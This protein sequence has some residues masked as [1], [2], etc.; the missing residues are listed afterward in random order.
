[1]SFQEL[2][3]SYDTE[4]NNFDSS[5]HYPVTECII[6]EVNDENCSMS[7]GCQNISYLHADHNQLPQ[8][9]ITD[10]D[11]IFDETAPE[12]IIYLFCDLLNVF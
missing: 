2:N 3:S 10:D 9:F 4:S 8:L 6:N 11:F 12:V 1:M 7:E 5:L